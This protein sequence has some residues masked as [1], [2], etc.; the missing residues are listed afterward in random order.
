MKN[1]YIF[2]TLFTLFMAPNVSSY[3]DFD[4]KRVQALCLAVSLFLMFFYGK[5]SRN[6]KVM[7][8]LLA[9][10]VIIAVYKMYTDRGEGSRMASLQILGAPIMLCAYWQITRNG[11]VPP[12]FVGLWR[13]FFNYV[14]VFFFVITLIAF[15]ERISGHMVFGW[16]DTTMTMAFSG[17]SDFRSYSI[18]G[19][20]LYNALVVTTFMSFILVSPLKAR[21]KLFLW[22]IGYASILCFNTRSSIVGNA[23]LMAAYIAYLIVID[24]TMKASSKR[25]IVFFALIVVAIG[26][27]MFF[28]AGLGGRLMEYGLFDESS[29]AVRIN[30]WDM[31]DYVDYK[32]MM[33]G[34]TLD[35]INIIKYKAEI[36]IIENFWINIL[37]SFGTVFFIPYVLLYIIL[38]VRLYKGW[39]WF[40]ACFSAGAFVLIAST[41]NSLSSCFFALF[42]FMLCIIMFSPDNFRRI[43]PNKYLITENLK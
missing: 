26:A 19:H 29:A 32:K 28:T 31:F 22:L 1:V 43:V 15:Y 23:L 12:A 42:F 9:L 11:V 24:R 14:I 25:S 20:S 18:M 38:V 13:K 8:V 30:L 21:I 4:Y 40:N 16:K 10:V 27:Y 3:L 39:N 17:S 35:E 37:F 5:V 34:M 41:N 7:N 36:G 33:W 6:L 2:L